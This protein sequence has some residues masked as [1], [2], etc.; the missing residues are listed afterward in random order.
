VGPDQDLGGGRPSYAIH[1]DAPLAFGAGSDTVQPAA[2]DRRNAFAIGV[3][4]AIPA[5]I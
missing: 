4:R 1:Q 5:G 3:A 2:G